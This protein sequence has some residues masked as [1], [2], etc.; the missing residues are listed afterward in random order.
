M[1]KKIISSFLTLLMLV[2]LSA[3]AVMAQDDITGSKFEKEAR[4]L[5][6]LNIMGGYKDGSFRPDAQISRA[7]YA[8]IIA[9]IMFDTGGYSVQDAYFVDVQATHW[10]APSIYMLADMGIINKSTRFK[11]DEA[12]TCYDAVRV[13]LN[14]LGYGEH[15]ASNGGYPEGYLSV[16]NSQQLLNNVVITT[17]NMGMTRGNVA[18]LIY[19][20]LDIKFAHIDD[21]DADQTIL[22]W[23]HIISG[24]G[25]VCAV[26]D[27]A[28]DGYSN[29]GIEEVLIVDN[30]GDAHLV[31][32]GDTDV[33]SML[34]QRGRYYIDE[35]EEILLYFGGSGSSSDEFYISADSIEEVGEDYIEYI[36]NDRTQR[37]SFSPS[38]AVIV[39]GERIYSENPTSYMWPELGGIRLKKSSGNSKYDIAYVSSYEAYIADVAIS[40]EGKLTFKSGISSRQ[41][42]LID[43]YARAEITRDGQEARLKDIQEWDVI[44]IAEKRDK[45]AITISASSGNRVSGAIDKIGSDTV[46]IGGK[47]YRVDWRVAESDLYPALRLTTTGI[48]YYNINNEIFAW[49]IDNSIDGT[50]GYLK[51]LFVDEEDREADSAI[52]TMDGEFIKYEYDKRV[53]ING[54]AYQNSELK[55]AVDIY[56]GVEVKDQL[57]RYTTGVNGKIKNIETAKTLGESRSSKYGYDDSQFT[58]VLKN[59]SALSSFIKMDHFNNGKFDDT[60]LADKDTKVIVVP[61]NLDK[62]KFSIMTVKEAFTGNTKYRDNKPLDIGEVMLYDA[63]RFLTVPIIVCKTSET[64]ILSNSID[65]NSDM[66]IID[67]CGVVRNADNEI[68]RQIS[69][70]YKGQRVTYEVDNDI[71][72]D[73][74]SLHW[75]VGIQFSLN[76]DNVIA[77]I[78]VLFDIEN[79][80][81]PYVVSSDNVV[82]KNETAGWN[83]NQ[84]IYYGNVYD[85]KD[86]GS[87]IMINTNYAWDHYR[88]FLSTNMRVYKY[89]AGSHTVANASYSDLMGTRSN[90]QKVV[91]RAYRSLVRELIIIED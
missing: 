2:N 16:A 74:D 36:K 9:R 79:S 33:S 49:K 52:Y 87:Q 68:V 30:N 26:H 50:Y 39:N 78:R 59:N 70:L 27:A 58:L 6:A 88:G 77:G 22:S 48:F 72:I 13:L 76:K 44:H 31:N 56:D 24:T 45:S 73:L 25:T 71:N 55:N 32:I 19:N 1:L 64:D 18:R 90:P 14:L 17:D 34:G 61:E 8:D 11:P 40:T 28:I 91:F 38:I 42:I 46:T 75:G 67:E 89:N 47:E 60:Y 35:N 51:N 54:V 23:K 4:I 80:K 53:V 69:G 10:A 65:Y 3:F 5:A 12:Q 84:L 82:G 62:N 83:S 63:D 66:I 81:D 41:Y 20:A 86:D 29:V 57:I 15:A 85:K 21:R 7:E 37:V 43:D